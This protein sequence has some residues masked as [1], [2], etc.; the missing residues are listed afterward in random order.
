MSLCLLVFLC[1]SHAHCQQSHHN[2]ALVAEHHDAESLFQFV[3]RPDIEAPKWDITI[4]DQEALAP[5]YWFLAPYANLQ[6]TSYPLWNGPHI[7]D[8]NGDL[9]WSGAPHFDHRNVYDFRVS[10]VNDTP[11]LT[12]NFPHNFSSGNAVILD[13]TYNT[14]RLVDMVGNN[15]GTN[16]HD[17]NLIDNGKRALFLTAVD[18]EEML[19][20]LPWFNGICNVGW[21]GFKEVDVD[22]GEVVFEW[23]AK[24]HISLSESTFLPKSTVAFSEACMKE[25][26]EC[27]R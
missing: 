15:S 3:T 22:T 24:D 4:Y 6:Q 11:M 10:I 26:G 16:M 17:F 14:N 19:V 18:L 21:Q 5:G 23:N 7:Y 9:I 2:P 1:F 25:W 13:E 12:A 27:V 20:S 8:Q